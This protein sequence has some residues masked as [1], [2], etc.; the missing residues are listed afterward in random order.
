VRRSVTRADAVRLF[1]TKNSPRATRPDSE[2][3]DPT[4]V[5]LKPRR[6]LALW[7]PLYRAGFPVSPVRIDRKRRRR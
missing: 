7:W 4:T 1:W 3:Q 2:V 5:R 6:F